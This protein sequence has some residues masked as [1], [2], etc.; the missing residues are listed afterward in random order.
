MHGRSVDQVD[1]VLTSG[2]T[3]FAPRDVTPEAV[4]PLLTKEAPGLVFRIMQVGREEEGSAACLPACP[5]PWLMV[6]PG[7][8]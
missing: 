7:P 2:G 5:W 1:L 8:V 3:G 4:R 6:L